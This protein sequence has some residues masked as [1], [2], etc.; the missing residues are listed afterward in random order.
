MFFTVSLYTSLLICGLGLAY[1]LWRWLTLNIGSESSQFG[2]GSRLAGAI[3]ASLGAIFSRHIFT[4]LKVFILD[5]LLQLRVLKHS[6]LAWFAHMAIFWGFILLVLMHALDD[7][8]RPFMPD[9]EST[10]DPYQFLRNFFG[11]LVLV[12]AAIA[13]WRRFKLP[14]R[15][16][17]ARSLD[18]IAVGLTAL[19]IISGFAFEG[20]K[21]VSYQD[22]D[23]MMEEYSPSD[24]PED[25]LALRTLW[26]KE[27]GVVFPT[28]RKLGGPEVLERGR[29]LDGE[30]CLECH[31]NTKSAFLSYGFG[32][33]IAPVAV[34][35]VDAGAVDLLWNIHFLATF[36]ALALL[37]FSK[38]LHLFTTPLL[39]MAGAVSQRDKMSPETKAFIRALELDA[40]MHCAT[41][42]V[43]CS[44]AVA[45][46][47]VPNLTLLP[48][49]KLRAIF[50]LAG[51]EP[52]GDALRAMREG[53]Y[54][55]TSCYRCTQMCPAGINLQDLWFAM[56]EDL[57]AKGLGETFTDVREAADRAAEP[58]RKQAQISLQPQESI[59]AGLSSEAKSFQNCFTCMT[60]TNA[61]PVVMNYPEPRQ[62]LD[63]LPHQ[64]MHALAVG[65]REEAMGAAMAWNCLTCYRC[66]EAC[67]QGVLV[68]E[69]LGELRN[70]AS[71][72][73]FARK[74]RICST[75]CS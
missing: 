69:V 46:H 20:M 3:K 63:L 10:I 18:H 37:P 44:V 36:A 30:S 9:Y 6:A 70:L 74:D 52:S 56:K 39:L 54:L 43:H 66:Q 14:I 28:D 47:E 15:K 48:S 45:L 57:A 23:R 68:T 75:L 62:V 31:S 64:I 72:S 29:E 8:T 21:I 11:L 60:C 42:S 71:H 27:Y 33:L 13:A 40:C 67:P 12:G 51:N 53:A 59:G 1:R 38:F 26:A 41:C 7:Y 24:E 35:L 32:K 5:G 16:L 65:L 25:K 61:C 58:S 17:T 55:C 4:L 73:D 19:I 34:K 22:Y 50:C 49:E 2:P